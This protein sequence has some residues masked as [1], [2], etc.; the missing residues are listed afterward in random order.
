[1][2]PRVRLIITRRVIGLR[3]LSSVESAAQ[4]PVPE[5]AVPAAAVA[6]LPPEKFT[7]SSRTLTVGIREVLGSRYARHM[8]DKGI[9]LLFA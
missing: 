3:A 9:S 6:F 7:D 1:M 2:I 5:A 8:R 4:T